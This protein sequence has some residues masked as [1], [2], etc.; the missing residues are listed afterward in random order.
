MKKLFVLLAATAVI[1]SCGLL[2][3]SS[4]SSSSSSEPAKA[5]ASAAP[6]FSVVSSSSNQKLFQFKSLPNNV[7]ELKAMKFSFTDPYAV[8]AMT[9]AALMRYEASQSDCYEMLNYLKGPEDLSSYEKNFLKERLQGKFYKVPSFF[10][11]ATPGNNYTPE[12]PY[13]IRVKTN[14]Y[15]FQGENWA[16]MQLTSGGS[17]SDRPLKLRKKPSTGEWFLNEITCL[18]DIRT[19]AN[20]D[21]WY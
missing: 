1:S 10:V 4:S 8:A 21:P 16:S 5:A 6:S 20:A 13:K 12:K 18:A 9:L 2:L 14:S 19:P 7:E 3:G 11:G 17:D 15:S